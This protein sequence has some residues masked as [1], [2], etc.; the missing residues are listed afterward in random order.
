[1]RCFRDNQLEP[2]SSSE[3]ENQCVDEEDD[4]SAAEWE[5]EEEEEETEEERANF[6]ESHERTPDGWVVG[7]N[8]SRLAEGASFDDLPR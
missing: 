2:S 4:D 7:T 8:S 5:E 6:C 1:M 3:D